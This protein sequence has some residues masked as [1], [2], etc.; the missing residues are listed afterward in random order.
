M[1]LKKQN[2]SCQV[3][4]SHVGSHVFFLFS[5]PTLSGTLCLKIAQMQFAS[6]E[7]WPV[8]PQE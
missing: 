2:K 4:P 1:S 7:M 5:L 8:V 6:R 3:P